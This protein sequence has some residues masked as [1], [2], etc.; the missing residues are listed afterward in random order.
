[1]VMNADRS[2]RITNTQ[3]LVSKN[4]SKQFNNLG[5]R[6]VKRVSPIQ[7]GAR[8]VVRNF[9]PSSRNVS[10]NGRVVRKKANNPSTPV[11]YSKSPIRSRS[12]RNPV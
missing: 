9:Q 6:K 7:N 12:R 1:M 8:K 5:P 4:L 3:R 10:S 2:D 11:R